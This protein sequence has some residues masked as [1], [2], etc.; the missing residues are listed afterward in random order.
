G[1]QSRV[2]AVTS[3]VPP[4]LCRLKSAVSWRFFDEFGTA[5]SATSSDKQQADT[6]RAQSARYQTAFAEIERGIAG[7][8]IT[9]A[10]AANTAITP[11]KESIRELTDSA[12]GVAQIKADAA[13]KSEAALNEI[14]D[15]T[16]W[17]VIFISFLVL[18]IAVGWNLFFPG[19]FLRSVGALRAAAAQLA[20]G[21]LTARVA[22]IRQDEFGALGQS[23]NTMADSLEARIA[24]EQAAQTE[25]QQLQHAEAAGRRALEQAVAEYLAFA[26]R[27]AQGD[28]TQRLTIQHSGAL[29]QLGQGLNG[30]VESLHAM[31]HRVQQA[32]A[33]IAAAAAEI[34]AATTQQAATA[35]EQSAAI[36][37][38]T[39]TVEEVKA[40]ALQTAHQAGKVAH[41]SQNALTVARQGTQAVEETVQGMSQIRAQ[42]ESIARTILALSEQTQAVG[43][44]ITTVSEL[45]DQSNLLALNA[46]I[47]AAR[48][49][50][51]GKS[52][53]VVAQHVRDLAERSKGATVQIREL[54]SEIQRATHAAVLV[55]EEGT[56]GVDVGG[57]LAGQ[58]GQV[59][60]GIAIEVESG[61]QANI[62]IAAGAHQQTAGMEQ[63][64]QAMASIQQATTQTIASTRQAERAAQDLHTLAQS[65]QH[66]I[67][68]YQL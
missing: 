8:T 2:H 37:Q 68:A 22:V 66:T 18:A 28:L 40:I 35:A 46:A 9:T 31:T 65:L 26:Q 6:W 59:I 61:A 15:R 58:A 67:A 43:M 29:G 1:A 16:T 34:L 41:D 48:A 4:F 57:R 49:G 36:T 11:F 13:E 55:T 17:Q 52:F 63:I 53:A 33:A 7:G 54:L 44:I 27:V 19:R 24:A 5:T 30:M 12:Q 50:E 51:Q 3:A 21:D 42:V 38:T 20:G 10:E 45:A 23:F 14:G 56:K 32:N 39:T 25:A 62:Q 64:G 47:E 60:H